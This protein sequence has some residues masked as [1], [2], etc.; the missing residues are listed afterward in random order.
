[1]QIKCVPKFRMSGS[2]FVLIPK[3]NVLFRSELAKLTFPQW[4]RG[5]LSGFWQLKSNIIGNMIAHI[6]RVQHGVYELQH[7]N[8][9]RFMDIPP[10]CAASRERVQWWYGRGI[11]RGFYL[12][13]IR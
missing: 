5:P 1:M 8:L 13:N 9:I 7:L 3:I 4:S 6:F 10:P 2:I 12:G 11:V